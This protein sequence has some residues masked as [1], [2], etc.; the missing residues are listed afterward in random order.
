MQKCFLVAGFTL[1][2]LLCG[3]CERHSASEFVGIEQA[4]TGSELGQKKDTPETPSDRVKLVVSVCGAV[5]ASA[6]LGLSIYMGYQT[7]RHNR[8]SVRPFLDDSLRISPAHTRISLSITN[9]GLGPA[10]VKRWTLLVDGQ[11]YQKL[12]ITD[13]ATL[14]EY[15]KLTD[16]V[17]YGYFMPHNIIA[18]D[19]TE[20][21]VGTE[22]GAYSAERARLY[23]NA[24]RRLT[25]TLEY[26]SFY[27]D[28]F[29]YRFEGS[30]LPA[31]TVA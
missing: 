28:Y 30:R 22:T 1:F 2:V 15:L 25:I 7:R 13:W 18:K 10:I 27:G 21:L 26:E 11:P 23:R 20:E 19:Q 24:F 17:T 5:T 6:A 29:T 4:G 12:G 3:G 8:L 16:K 14:T 31:E 9:R